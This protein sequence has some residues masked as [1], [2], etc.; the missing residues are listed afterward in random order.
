MFYT[1][2]NTV[3]VEQLMNDALIL[4]HSTGHDVF[5]A[6]D[7]FENQKILKGEDAEQQQG[8]GGRGGRAPE[9]EGE[10][11]GATRR[12]ELVFLRA[13]FSMQMRSHRAILPC[14]AQVWH[15]RWKIAVLPLQLAGGQGNAGKRS[16]A[17]HAVRCS[18]EWKKK[19]QL[20]SR[21]F[22]FSLVLLFTPVLL[23]QPYTLYL[24]QK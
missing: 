8:G 3:P 21:F 19:L 24:V 13:V 23:R 9:G 4:A 11:A 10:G 12:F 17:G 2:P 15:R 14:R 18:L 7:I 20:L 1:V 5:N 16:G 6:L 22:S